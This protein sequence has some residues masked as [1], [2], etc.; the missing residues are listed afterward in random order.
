MPPRDEGEVK[1]PI[2]REEALEDARRLLAMVQDCLVEGT[3]C[4]VITLTPDGQDVRYSGT[5][6]RPIAARVMRTL[7]KD[8][9]GDA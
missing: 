7:A 6:T 4:I 9:E 5:V 2:P 3:C 8:L 1:D